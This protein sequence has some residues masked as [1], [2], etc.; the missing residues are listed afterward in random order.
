MAA[1]FGAACNAN[2]AGHG[3]MLTD[4]HV[5]ADLYL[6]VDLDAV[7]NH[8]V[9][10]RSTIDAGIGANFHIIA[11]LHTA[12]LLDLD[13]APLVTGKA[14]TIAANHGAGLH[15]HPLAQHTISTNADA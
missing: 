2:A 5:V 1:N 15:Q 9:A 3:R 14:K 6:V 7:G 10:Q 12:E 8:G 11:N 13:P 4:L